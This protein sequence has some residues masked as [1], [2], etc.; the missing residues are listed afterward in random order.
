VIELVYVGE[1]VVEGELLG[2]KPGGSGVGLDHSVAVGLG[3]EM[4]RPSVAIAP[5]DGELFNG[6]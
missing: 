1:G 4:E 3:V 6:T 5:M 2:V